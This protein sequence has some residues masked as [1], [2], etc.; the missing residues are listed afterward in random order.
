MVVFLI[1]YDSTWTYKK[2]QKRCVSEK[3]DE[4]FF[5]VEIFKLFHA[6][7]LSLM[8]STTVQNLSENGQIAKILGQFEDT[9]QKSL[10]RKI[11]HLFC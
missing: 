7:M 9:H 8:R 5:G 11:N 2:S 10:N 4:K 6:Q 3:S 1:I